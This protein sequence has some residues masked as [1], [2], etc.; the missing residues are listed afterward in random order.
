MKTSVWQKITLVLLGLSLSLVL[1]EAGLRL[2]G[3]IFSSVQAYENFRSAKQKNTYRILCIGES[4]TARQYP[5]LLEQVLNRRNIGVRFSVIDKGRVA[6][7]TVILLEEIEFNLAEFHPNMVVAMMGINDGRSLRMPFGIMT[8]SEGTP[9]IR[10][11]RTYKL[12]R[13]LWLHLLTKAKEMRLYRE[14]GEFDQAEASF[15]KAI[16]RNPKNDQAYTEIGWLYNIQRKNFQA[17]GFLKRALEINPKNVKACFGLGVLYFNRRELSR[18]E[19]FFKKAIEIDPEFG[20][21][22]AGLGQLYKAQS[23]YAQAEVSYKKAAAL[24]P[25]SEAA[26]F[27]LG[28]IY[29]DQGKLSQSEDS[30]RRAIEIYPKSTR[31]LGAISSLYAQMGKPELAKE[32]VERANGLR[33]EYYGVITVKNHRK[34]KEIL[35]GKGIKLVC[36]QY[37]VRNIEPLKKI[38]EKDEGVIFVDNE[39]IFKEA[40]RKE[41]YK[42][43]FTDMFAGDFGHCTPKG[44]MLLAQN[45]ADVILKE[46][47]NK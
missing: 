38:F 18:S 1:L 8:P 47:F 21:A 12:A 16:K 22:H 6:M 3:F 30:F 35:D 5:H 13:L 34:L 36:V 19:I 37:P 40:L 29:R 10:S 45:I 11:L 9:F 31:A 44:N 24:G 32:Y 17:E 46:V 15:R 23:N 26:Y 2:G 28:V 39:H 4:T 27:G 43:Y 33:S 14:R 42:D 25:A 41:S 7:N 20:D